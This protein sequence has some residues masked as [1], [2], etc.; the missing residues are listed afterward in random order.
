MTAKETI[1]ADHF[2]N[3]ITFDDFILKIRAVEKYF[4]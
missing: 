3:L 4:E 1:P 2:N